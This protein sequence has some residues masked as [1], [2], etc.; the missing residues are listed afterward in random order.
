MTHIRRDAKTIAA[1]LSSDDLAM[2]RI[3]QKKMKTKSISQTIVRAIESVACDEVVP[4]DVPAVVPPVVQVAVPADVREDIADAV[5]V[6]RR[7]GS[8]LSQAMRRD[9]SV[10]TQVADI[11]DAAARLADIATR[12]VDAAVPASVSAPKHSAPVSDTR[13][14]AEKAAAAAA[15]DALLHAD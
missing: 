4:A 11:Y 15:L 5:K 9:G 3:A 6:L 1:R 7:S 14:A 13:S 8:N 12:L 10:T 2:L